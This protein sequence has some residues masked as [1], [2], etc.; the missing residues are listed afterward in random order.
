MI[1][2]L[3][4]VFSVKVLWALWKTGGNYFNDNFANNFVWEVLFEFLTT[5]L[6]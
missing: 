4:T 1:S 5:L 3:S 6:T 2:G